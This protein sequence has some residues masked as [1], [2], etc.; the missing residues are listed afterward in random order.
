MKAAHTRMRP[1][2]GPYHAA[3]AIAN[4]R[5]HVDAEEW[6]GEPIPSDPEA[7]PN[8]DGKEECRESCSP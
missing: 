8:L 3:L 6:H 2:R 4:T 7:L 5:N 1:T